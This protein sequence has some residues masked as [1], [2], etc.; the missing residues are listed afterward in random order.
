MNGNYHSSS[1]G[2]V[3]MNLIY[4]SWVVI[5]SIFKPITITIQSR[6]V[7]FIFS[8]MAISLM[9]A[10]LGIVRDTKRMAKELK[11]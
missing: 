10:A 2:T 4:H 9:P 11:S 5:N 6:S 3:L 8:R 7:P 1:L